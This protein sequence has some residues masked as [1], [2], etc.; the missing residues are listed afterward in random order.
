MDQDLQPVTV[1]AVNDAVGTQIDRVHYFGKS[2]DKKTADAIL[3]E[4]VDADGDCLLLS[5]VKGDTKQYT[6]FYASDD[7]K[8]TGDLVIFNDED[9][10]A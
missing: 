7:L 4:W 8:E 5:A 6:F 10:D 2:Y 3:S 9:D 1:Q